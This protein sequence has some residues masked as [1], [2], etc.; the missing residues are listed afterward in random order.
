MT[1]LL[2]MGGYARFVWP[3]YGITFAVIILNI[4][5]ARRLLSQAR[6]QVRRRLAMQAEPVVQ[7][8]HA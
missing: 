7:A 6:D 3:S 5:W 1:H 4:L 8:E 2:Q